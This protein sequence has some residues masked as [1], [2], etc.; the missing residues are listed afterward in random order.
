MALPIVYKDI[1]NNMNVLA[2]VAHHQ[3]LSVVGDALYFENRSISWLMRA[4]TGDSRVAI[5]NA[6]E[7]TFDKAEELLHCYET[8]TFINF[9]DGHIHP[10]ELGIMMEQLKDM[11]ER[12]DSVCEGLAH[13]GTFARYA[14]D[15]EFQLN[16]ETFQKRMRNLARGCKAVLDQVQHRLEHHAKGDKTGKACCNHVSKKL[17]VAEEQ[18]INNPTSSR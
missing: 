2:R 16:V 18:P 11:G 6:I 9:Q 5:M 7:K 1:M 12:K 8:S 15:A 17:L 10:H 14:D 3:T 13:L 4:V